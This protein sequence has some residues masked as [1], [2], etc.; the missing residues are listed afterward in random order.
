M[1]DKQIIDLFWQRSESAISAVSEK[2]GPYCSKIAGNILEIKEDVE[3]CVNDTWLLVWQIIPP[4]R[5][6]RL[7]A[8]LGKIVRNV[9]LNRVKYFSAEKRGFG[10]TN[11]V[12]SELEECVPAAD[13]VEQEMDERI[14][15]QAIGRFL[16]SLPAGRRNIFIRRYW[17]MMSVKEIAKIYG[18]SESKT[19]SLLFRKRKDLKVHLQKEGILV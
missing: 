8:Y 6:V 17:Y 15:I 14:L 10:Q 16:R 2:Y 13:N 18:M 9:S 5:P 3:E 19:A 11:L 1:E 4:D 7:A 12:L